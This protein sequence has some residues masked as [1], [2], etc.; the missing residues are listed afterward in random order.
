MLGGRLVPSLDAPWGM[1]SLWKVEAGRNVL[2]DCGGVQSNL[3]ASFLSV[4]PAERTPGRCPTAPLGRRR[5]R[6]SRLGGVSEEDWREAD[7][8]P[9]KEAQNLSMAFRGGIWAENLKIVS[10]LICAATI[11]VHWSPK[12]SGDEASFPCLLDILSGCQRPGE[13]GCSEGGTPHRDW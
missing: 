6:E 3:Q 13:G 2:G 8:S 11:F 12:G 5:S 4:S 1:G 7:P 9:T 10:I